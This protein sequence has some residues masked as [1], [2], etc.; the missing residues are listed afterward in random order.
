MVAE[1]R[2]FTAIVKCQNAAIQITHCRLHG[3][4]SPVARFESLRERTFYG[5]SLA[6]T[7]CLSQ[8]FLG[9]TKF[10]RLRA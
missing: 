6:F 8:I 10:A 7:V 5:E 4:A 2:R 3:E 9:T 1:G